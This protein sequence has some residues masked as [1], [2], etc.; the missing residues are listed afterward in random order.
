MTRDGLFRI[1]DGKLAGPVGDL[2]FTY[3]FLDLLASVDAVGAAR[4]LV[5]GDF[6]PTLVPALRARAFTFTGATGDAA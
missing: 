2:R 1:V 6:G 3:G 4:V 5:P